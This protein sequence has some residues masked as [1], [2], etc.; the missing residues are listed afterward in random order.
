MPDD[1]QTEPEDG[2]LTAEPL[3][4]VAAR[5]NPWAGRTLIMNLSPRVLDPV[6][7][8]EV[9]RLLQSPPERDDG[10]DSVTVLGPPPSPEVI[11]ALASTAQRGREGRGPVAM[12]PSE[13]PELDAAT[14]HARSKLASLRARM[15]DDFRRA[16]R[17]MRI[18]LFALPVVAWA[19]LGFGR[20]APELAPP[21]EPATAHSALPPARAPHVE[22]ARPL[23]LPARAPVSNVM[24][25]RRTLE[26]TAADAAARGAF[27][28]ALNLYRELAQMSPE[29]PEF[30][31]AVRILQS[32]HGQQ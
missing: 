23:P 29:R 3:V 13:L 32:K 11:A 24:R 20:T 7:A 8:Q 6:G 9:T 12:P 10:F 27:P 31:S 1:E 15:A 4:P 18:L 25:G 16:P 17:S 14:P 30:A 5:A 22:P 2:A 19:A 26:A 21:A 28:E